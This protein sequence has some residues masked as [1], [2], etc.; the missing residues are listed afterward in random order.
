MVRAHLSFFVINKQIPCAFAVGEGDLQT[1]SVV[2]LLRL[3]DCVKILHGDY[4]FG[5]L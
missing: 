2:D 5:K 4:G 3:K 1:V